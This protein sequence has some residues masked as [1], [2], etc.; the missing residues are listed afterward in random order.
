M[1][2]HMRRLRMLT[3]LF[4]FILPNLL[5][6][7]PPLDLSKVDS[8]DL[9]GYRSLERADFKGAHAP[10]Q[11]LHGPVLPV[12]VSCIY[13]VVNPR[14]R[15]YAESRMIDGVATFIP[16]ISDLAFQ[17]VLS[18]SCSWWNDE[19]NV[20]PAYVL[21]H[22]QVHFALYEIA[23]RKLNKDA[24][25][26]IRALPVSTE[27]AQAAVTATQRF[28]Q[29]RLN[30]TMQQVVNDNALFDRETSFGFQPE[31]QQR[32]RK[33]VDGD[34]SQLTEHTVDLELH[35]PAGR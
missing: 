6:A 22:E 15:I 14:A 9:T 29:E 30:R 23:S 4:L 26:L 20:S 25:G 2:I 11:F 33:T 12:A 16:S 3:S 17:A 31:R 5:S 7:G 8:L 18:R 34:L 21:E 28:L 1:F 24:V 32:W 35:P 13:V 10:K 19:H 27:S